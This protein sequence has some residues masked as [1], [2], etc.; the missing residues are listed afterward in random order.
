MKILLSSLFFLL[1]TSLS[2]QV[3]VN[4]GSWFSGRNRVEGN[5]ELETQSRNLDGFTGVHTCCSFK[6]EL[7]QSRDFGVKVEAESNL[8]EFIET[9]VI[10]NTLHIR[11]TDDANFKSKRDIRVYVSLPRLEAVDASSSARVTGKT[12]FTGEDLALDVSSSATIELDFTG[13]RVDLDASSSG[14]ITV[15]GSASRVTADASSAS[16]IDAA[17]LKAEDAVAD[18][19]SAASVNVH[20]TNSLRADASSAGVVRYGG[21]PRDVVADTSS[22]GRV[23]S[24]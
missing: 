23:R 19:S 12:P 2:A 15:G 5:G 1:L 8:Q 9:R 20:V 22:A 11:F 24:N 6:V 21:N 3:E 10:G 13:Q 16:T 4:N 7:T 18:V 14:R 17:A